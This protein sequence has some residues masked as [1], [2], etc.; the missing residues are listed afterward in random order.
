[1]NEG[2]LCFQSL[3]SC[4]T[5]NS[6][7]CS[8]VY[9]LLKVVRELRE[10]LDRLRV[11]LTAGTQGQVSPADQKAIDELRDKLSISERLMKEMTMTWEEKLAQTE[12]IH[13]VSE[14]MVCRHL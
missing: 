10:E 1:M 4:L 14:L 6:V 8:L 3:V 2:L 5:D 12:R 13:K 9:S 7:L 11:M